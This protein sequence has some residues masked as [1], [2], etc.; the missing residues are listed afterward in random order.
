LWLGNGFV[1]SK[2]LGQYKHDLHSWAAALAPDGEILLYGCNIAAGETGRQFV[3]LL[4]QLTGANVAA[5]SN[6]TGSAALG[7]DW[8]LEVKIGLV[9]S[10]IAFQG[11]TVEAYSAV[12]ATRRVSI[13]TDGTQG[14][15]S[16]SSLSS[17]SPSISADGRY[18]AFHSY[19]NNLVSGDTNNNSDIFIKDL[20]TGNTQ[21]IALGSNGTQG[22][23]ASS[24]PSIST[25]GRY[26]AFESNASNL[27][28]GDTNSSTDI[29]ITDV[30]TGTTKR[31]STATDGTQ[32]NSFS[33]NPPSIS[34]N[35]NFVA[36]QSSASN[37]VSG[38]SNNSYDIFVKDVQIGT[39]QRISVATDGTQGNG[40]SRGPSFS[41]N[42]NFVAFQSSASNLVSG[43]T[44]GKSD[45][46]IRNLQTNIT[47]RISA[48][49]DGTQGNGDSSSASLSADGRYVVFMSDASNLVSGDTNGKSDIFARNLQTG[50][51]Q[52]IS[53]ASDGTQG[54]SGSSHPSLSADGRS[55]VFVSNASNLVSGDTNGKSDIFVRDLQTGI[56]QRISAASDG[57]QGN[58]NSN[59]PSISGDGSYVAFYSVASNL[60]SGDTNNIS[61]IFVYD[62]GYGTQNPWT[63]TPFDDTYTYTGTA[64]F[65]GSGL[66]GNDTI[67]GGIGN[68]ILDGGTGNDSLRG[69]KGNDTYY[70]DSYRGDTI[71]EN[72]NEGT[73]TVI[74]S[75]SYQ[76]GNNLE[77]LTLTSTRTYGTGNSLDNVITGS[78]G[79]NNL[80][81]Q[82]GNDTINGAAGN[83]YLNGND[84]NDRL[85]GGDG[86]D[87]LLGERGSDF[88][89]GGNGN[90][91][92]IGYGGTSGERDTLVG[93][94]GSDIFGIG[95]NYARF[96]AGGGG[97]VGYT[98]DGDTGF[99]LIRGWDSTDFIELKGDFN[100]YS[101]GQVFNYGDVNQADLTISYRGSNG[102]DLIAVLQD[103]TDLS[104]DSFIF[105]T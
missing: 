47:Q 15:N 24:F 73:D 45:I 101:F 33:L 55:V 64:N 52:R 34:G 83:D 63:G 39:T 56:T 86:N 100:Q 53:V 70:V 54:N 29:F 5:S 76:L 50:I 91:L 49:T 59:L 67:I 38:D 80:R 43:D 27:V 44:N 62:R 77:N 88:L 58:D 51:T 78:S 26:V 66:A 19:A 23:G 60:V 8:E 31:I 6:L 89:S 96:G 10:P 42:G 36:F 17:Y 35:G 32:G 2:T 61:D 92:L 22:N 68:D 105:F 28:D 48:A 9:G 65:T 25:N 30:Q 97:L 81:G 7:G 18:V 90:D 79:E 37:L 93:G 75:Q 95:I 11:E 3:Q 13:A 85:D 41:G 84:G 104:P 102:S 98:G 16:N 57:T 82:A 69:G 40:D 4:G 72:L 14:S 46:F 1:D 99:A 103:A 20:Q 94:A 12:L 74:S 87:T 71:V 21:R